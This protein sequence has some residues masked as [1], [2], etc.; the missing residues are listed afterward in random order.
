MV[1][2]YKHKVKFNP[3]DLQLLFNYHN[4]SPKYNSKP[5]STLL[6]LLLLSLLL[7][8]LLLLFLQYYYS[9]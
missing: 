8:L 5:N 7:L 4:I 1:Q 6:L 9:C 3:S 2:R